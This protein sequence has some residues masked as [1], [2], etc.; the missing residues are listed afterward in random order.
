MTK[1]LRTTTVRAT[2]RGVTFVEM[3]VTIA[4]FSIIILG[5]SVFF[6]RM[7][8]IHRFTLETGIASFIAQRGVDEVVEHIRR[9]RSSQNGA[10]AIASADSDSIRFY[11]DYDDDGTVERVHYFLENGTLW[12]GVTEPMVDTGGI[13]TYAEDDD[14]VR[15]IADHVINQSLGE[16]TFIYYG[17]DGKVF[18]YNDIAE[19]I[20]I[21]PVTLAHIRM[22]KIVLYVNPDAVRAPNHVHIQSFAVVR[23]LAIYDKVQP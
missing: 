12:R 1:R 23:N 19:N 2:R 8:T 4:I 5:S 6:V 20:L 14:T 7:W 18:S 13:I 3:I 15:S 16:A 9:A 11:D 21:P 22:V 17:T 10:F